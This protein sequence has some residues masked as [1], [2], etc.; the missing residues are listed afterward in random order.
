MLKIT[1][2]KEQRTNKERYNVFI[3]DEFSFSADM[4]DVV[5]YSISID[6]EIE[7]CELEKLKNTC[8]FSKAHKYAL[9][10]ISKM[11]Y[12]SFEITNKLKLKGYSI[13]TINEVL[14]KLYYYKFIDDEKYLKKYISYCLR[15]K[16]YG[17]NKIIAELRKRGFNSSDIEEIKIDEDEEYDNIKTAAIKKLNSLE[18]KENLKPKLY[19]YLLSKGYEYDLI[20][21]A[22]DEVS[23]NEL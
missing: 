1:D 10:L 17:K 18:G 21:K 5:K 8:E 23:D 22:I 20:K 9:T 6:R 14:D 19:R 12:T 4:E 13:D 16:K 2:I 3:D 7:Q 11:D 15:I